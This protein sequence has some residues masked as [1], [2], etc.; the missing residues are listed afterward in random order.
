MAS[1]EK[2]L[3]DQIDVINE[4]SRKTLTGIDSFSDYGAF[5]RIGKLQEVYISYGE[6]LE[7]RIDGI[8][9]ILKRPVEKKIG[10]VL[11]ENV[12][13]LRQAVGI[14]ENICESLYVIATEEHVK[15]A[16]RINEFKKLLGEL[17][18]FMRY[19]ILSDYDS[20]SND[21][22]INRATEI[23][24]ETSG[25]TGDY[26]P[27][28]IFVNRLCRHYF[29]TY[30][31]DDTAIVFQG[32]I[33]YEYD[34]TI[35]TLYRYRRLYPNVPLIVSTW[36]NEVREEFRWRA[37]TIGVDIL[38]NKYPERSGR[39][40]INYQLCSSREGIKCA[41]KKYNI[42]YAMKC[43]TDQRFYQ[44]DFLVY[45]KNE[46]KLFPI[47]KG[48]DIEERLIFN[49]VNA[50]MWSY[51]FR[52]S[53]FWSF[54][55]ANDL[56]KLYSIPYAE[57]VGGDGHIKMWEDMSFESEQISENM[58]KEERFQIAKEHEDVFDSEAYII[59]A[60]YETNILGRKLCPDDDD[61]FMHYWDFVKDY[62]VIEDPDTLLMYWPKYNNAKFVFDRCTYGG[63]MTHSTWLN[64]YMNISYV[65]KTL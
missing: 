10:I 50:S 55:T 3:I 21:K 59:R 18:L 7:D 52:L 26:Y 44:P 56:I 20:E 5:A 28:H 48:S 14:I 17:T 2:Q 60:F 1:E 35:E 8:S 15:K 46:L 41:K 34:F 64:A 11:N 19:E 57:D 43:R 23:L 54:G 39:Y 29:P 13:K 47:K 32:Q 9:D 49:G 6:L 65:K 51:P 63:T 45:L 37:E 25:I 27:I 40:H 30:D 62:V 22:G 36:E 4:L 53:D 24:K 38:E 58:T 33:K 12:I 31:I 61:I 42:K 16:E